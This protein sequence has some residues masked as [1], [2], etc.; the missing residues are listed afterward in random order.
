[1]GREQ[2]VVVWARLAAEPE[3]TLAEHCAWWE[4]TQGQRVRSATMARAIGRLR[5]TRKKGRWVP[6]SGTKR[7]G[8]SGDRP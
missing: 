2:E 5:W 1:M 4:Q 3:A 7:H 8:S 6:P